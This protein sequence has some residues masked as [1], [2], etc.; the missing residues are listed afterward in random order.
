MLVV[1]V[2]LGCS[3]SLAVTGQPEVHPEALESVVREGASSP[4]A[5][6][7]LLAATGQM[8]VLV[9]ED[10]GGAVTFE[11]V[12]VDGSAVAVWHSRRADAPRLVCVGC[13]LPIVGDSN[14]FSKW[15]GGAWLPAD[16]PLPPSS[17]A[18]PLVSTF[19]VI[20]ETGDRVALSMVVGPIGDYLLVGDGGGAP[21]FI[22]TG[23][24]PAAGEFVDLTG[25]PGQVI[26]PL[27]IVRDPDGA[28]IGVQSDPISPAATSRVTRSSGGMTQERTFEGSPGVPTANSAP[29]LRLSAEAPSVIALSSR[30]LGQDD[31]ARPPDV[32]ILWLSQGLTEVARVSTTGFFDHCA[33]MSDGTAVLWTGTTAGF[34]AV[35]VL[36]ADA[37]GN[38]RRSSAIVAANSFVSTLAR[39]GVGDGTLEAWP[40]GRPVM[41]IDRDGRTTEGEGLGG[42]Q[43]LQDDQGGRWVWF[44]ALH[45]VVRVTNASL[46]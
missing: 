3:V 22:P 4:T 36:S 40:L 30:A 42:N 32:L 31:Q 46:R 28:V 20:Q 8:A 11:F 7:S 34:G 23:V 24:R 9:S 17:L 18:D 21:S 45:R 12:D 37:S 25:G 43:V 14:G 44:S 1:L 2:L 10:I 6:A 15:S 29:C 27:A 5:P 16:L 19:G 41:L 38:V 39:R 13:P 26:A 33:S 35:D